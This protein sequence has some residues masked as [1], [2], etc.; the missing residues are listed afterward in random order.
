MKI[1]TSKIKRIAK[2]L[3]QY[4]SFSILLVFILMGSWCIP[5]KWI[6][7]VIRELKS[8]YTVENV[9]EDDWKK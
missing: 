8:K 5:P 2:R 4:T 3:L 6:E 1:L 9:I 7:K